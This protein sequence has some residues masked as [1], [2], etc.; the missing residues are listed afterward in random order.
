MTFTSISDHEIRHLH[1]FL[2][3]FFIANR[4]LDVDLYLN[5]YTG[6]GWLVVAG[7]ALLHRGVE[8]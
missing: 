2:P 1:D 6:L 4:G 3:Q 7:P 8:H 5:G